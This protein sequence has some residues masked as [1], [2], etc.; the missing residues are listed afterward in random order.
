MVGPLV[1]ISDL[2]LENVACVTAASPRKKSIF[3]GERR[4]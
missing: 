4:L 3:Y 1:K 2:E